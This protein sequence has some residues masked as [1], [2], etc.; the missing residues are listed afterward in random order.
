MAISSCLRDPYCMSD[1]SDPQALLQS[2]YKIFIR[3]KSWLLTRITK[4]YTSL[5]YPVLQYVYKSMNFI[6]A[7]LSGNKSFAGAHVHL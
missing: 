1:L 3:Q 6:F 2:K 4:I 5:R 7:H